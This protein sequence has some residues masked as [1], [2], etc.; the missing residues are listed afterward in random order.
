MNPDLSM[1][2]Q[3][4]SVRVYQDREVDDT[5]VKDLLEAAMTAPSAMAKDPWHFVVVRDQ[6]VR[7]R[8]VEQL[9]NGKMLA[10][11]PVGIVICGDLEQAHMHSLPYLLLD[12]AAATQ[13]LLLAAQALGLGAVWLGVYPRERRVEHVRAVLSLPPHVLPVAGVAMGWP[14]EFPEPRTRYRDEAVHRE[15]W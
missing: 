5:M 7:S 13:S 10:A 6:A 9:P 12:C 1:F 14:A 11:A 4:R 3:R 8:L 15:A 2:F